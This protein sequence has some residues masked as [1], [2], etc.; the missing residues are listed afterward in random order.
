MDDIPGI[1]STPSQA[2]YGVGVEDDDD[3]WLGSGDPL[4]LFSAWLGEASASEPNDPHA[5]NLAT[6]DRDGFPDSR[7]VLLKGVDVQGF[8]FYTNMES[9]KGIQLRA[10]PR[11][12]LNFHWKTLRRQVRVRGLIGLAEEAESDAYFAERARDSQLGAWASPQSRPIASRNTLIAAMRETG[13]RFGDGPVPRPPHWGGFRL[14]PL[15]IEFW[16]DRRFRLHDRL[17]FQRAR[18]QDDW[19]II[20]LAP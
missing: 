19:E 5:M 11:A 7:I 20:R 1:P 6:A 16:R 9:A 18:L 10:N 15:R 4:A 13:R 12:A 17:L 3:A 14:A 2:E 8:V